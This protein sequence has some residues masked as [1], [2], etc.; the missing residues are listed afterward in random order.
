M[1]VASLSSQLRTELPSRWVGC[2]SM[3]V[4]RLLCGLHPPAVTEGETKTKLKGALK[5]IIKE[6]RS[7]SDMEPL[8]KQDTT[9]DVLRHVLAAF[10]DL[11]PADVAMRRSFV[12]SGALMNLQVRLGGSRMVWQAVSLQTRRQV[13][14]TS[15]EIPHMQL[16][17]PY[18][19]ILAAVQ[20]SFF[21]LTIQK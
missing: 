4:T 20:P 6:C 16:R 15:Q 1:A 19:A 17:K 21:W 8:V 12:T 18:N 3:D 13:S 11:L 7:H 5:A 2:G 9:A 10:A 14:A